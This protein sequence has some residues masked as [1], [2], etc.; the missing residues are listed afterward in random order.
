MRHGTF[1]LVNTTRPAGHK[2]DLLLNRHGRSSIDVEIAYS[3]A[4]QFAVDRV[5]FGLD[6]P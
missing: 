3:H 4:I 6:V 1:M 2:H 5:Q